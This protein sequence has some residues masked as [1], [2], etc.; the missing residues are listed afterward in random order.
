[1]RCSVSRIQGKSVTRSREGKLSAKMDPELA[2]PPEL[3]DK[4]VIV[5]LSCVQK[6]TH[7]QLMPVLPTEHVRCSPYYVYV[8]LRR[9]E[10]VL[11]DVME[12][13]VLCKTET[14]VFHPPTQRENSH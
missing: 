7:S 9:P 4:D 11:T 6:Y 8:R 12:A 2:L 3:A 13:Q 10:R 1:M 14:Q 5:C